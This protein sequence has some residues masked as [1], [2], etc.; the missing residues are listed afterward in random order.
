[1]K[2]QD[3][4]DAGTEPDHAYC[5]YFIDA[6]QNMKSVSI[7]LLETIEFQDVK[8]PQRYWKKTSYLFEGTPILITSNNSPTI[9]FGDLLAHDNP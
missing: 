4:F 6:M 3:T 2:W 5:A 9:L 8:I 1:M 7:S